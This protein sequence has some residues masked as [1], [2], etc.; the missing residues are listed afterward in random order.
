MT[1]HKDIYTKFLIEYDKANITS[2]YP[3][4]T[5][6]EAA[7]IL[8]KAYLALVSQKVTGNN[9]RRA[10]FET[11]PKAIEDLRPLVF[12]ASPQP[13]DEPV[14]ASN[15]YT[16]SIPDSFLYYVSSS[17]DTANYNT[18]LDKRNHTRQP[19]KLVTHELA[20]KY[21]STSTNMPWVR[22]PVCYFEHNRIHVLVDPYEHY[23]NHDKYVKDSQKALNDG[24]EYTLTY[25][26][27]F[28]KFAIGNGIDSTE[29]DFTDTPFELSDTMA[30]ELISLAVAFATETVENPRLT[31]KL[32][33]RPLEA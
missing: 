6:Y 24:F 14:D 13:I 12:K 7:T 27:K 22:Q 1:T 15:E 26:C 18:A 17:I 3:S 4:L 10:S 31:T 25:I 8:D 9:V 23:L 32:N 33:T 16:Y 11:D 29:Y 2:S 28:K 20:Q 30:E 21:M 5:E 19:V